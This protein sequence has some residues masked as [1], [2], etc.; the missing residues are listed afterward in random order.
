MAT[1]P[2]NRSAPTS[3]PSRQPVPAGIWRFCVENPPYGA[4][5]PGR[6]TVRIEVAP[7]TF[8]SCDRRQQA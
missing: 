1:Q 4:G 5:K 2:Q 6:N 3:Q 7:P 8:G